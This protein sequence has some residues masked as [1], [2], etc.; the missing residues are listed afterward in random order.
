MIHFHSLTVLARLGVPLSAET[1]WR[2][3]GKWADRASEN[4]DLWPRGCP[5]LGARRPSICRLKSRP[6]ARRPVGRAARLVRKVRY[7]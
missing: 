1:S 3:K 2:L 4:R 5:I 7:D 6:R